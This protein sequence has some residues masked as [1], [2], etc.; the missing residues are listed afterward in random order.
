MANERWGMHSDA[1]L[2]ILMSSGRGL[3]KKKKI[4]AFWT[5]FFL[6]ILNLVHYQQMRLLGQDD[7]SVVYL[8]LNIY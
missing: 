5:N 7:L 4:A 8:Y 2:L 1:A 6:S 3:A